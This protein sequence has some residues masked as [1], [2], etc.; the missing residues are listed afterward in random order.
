MKTTFSHQWRTQANLFD[1]ERKSTREINQA[2]EATYY[3]EKSFQ[4]PGCEKQVLLEDRE[5]HS[6]SRPFCVDLFCPCHWE[7]QATILL[8]SQLVQNHVLTDGEAKA[9][10]N[11]QRP[12]HQREATFHQQQQRRGA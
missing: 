7:D 2:G 10:F 8:L 11:G 6:A 5:L 12:L 9:V 4:F 3:Y 1:V